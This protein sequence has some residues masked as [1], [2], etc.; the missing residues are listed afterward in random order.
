MEK[1]GHW[2]AFIWVWIKTYSTQEFGVDMNIS[3]IFMKVSEID[4][5]EKI[6]FSVSWLWLYVLSN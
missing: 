3:M 5:L 1:P 2:P 6:L 4:T